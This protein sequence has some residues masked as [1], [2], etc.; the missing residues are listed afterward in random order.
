ME[1]VMAVVS[2]MTDDGVPMNPAAVGYILFAARREGSEGAVDAAF[3][4]FLSL[5][6]YLQSKQ[7]RLRVLL[8]DEG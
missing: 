5:N 1:V 3:D 2:A 8:R 4:V 7:V 6:G